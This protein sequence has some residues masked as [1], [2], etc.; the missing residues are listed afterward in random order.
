MDYDF[1]L[2]FA[3]ENDADPEQ[4]LGTLYEAGCDDASVGI[5]KI[6]SI[7]LDFPRESDSAEAA[8]KS[9]IADVKKAIPHAKLIKVVP[10]HLTPS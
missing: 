9:A 10:D 4:Y 7:A 3:L 1:V 2:T 5:G 6:G 8:V